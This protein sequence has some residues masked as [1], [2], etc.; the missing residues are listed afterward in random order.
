MP[1]VSRPHTAY[2]PKNVPATSG[3]NITSAPG[4]TMYFSA[5]LVEIAMQRCCCVF[6]GGRKQRRDAKSEYASM[7][8]VI[9]SSYN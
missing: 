6:E 1:P 2:T 8:S 9:I 3:A 4:A 5:A 7:L